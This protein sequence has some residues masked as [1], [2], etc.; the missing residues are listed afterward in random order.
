MPAFCFQIILYSQ[1]PKR[2]EKYIHIS[3]MCVCA[4]VLHGD[5][6]SYSQERE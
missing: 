2:K 1:Y 3:Y 4:K 6:K 5:V